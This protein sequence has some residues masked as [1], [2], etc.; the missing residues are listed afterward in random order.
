MM[1]DIKILD[2][3]GV[4]Y[5]RL[6]GVSVKEVKAGLRSFKQGWGLNGCSR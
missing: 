4:D 1:I 5:N 3:K 6:F 2:N